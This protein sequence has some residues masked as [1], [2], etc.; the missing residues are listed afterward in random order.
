MNDGHFW[1][2]GSLVPDESRS[3]GRAGAGS[4]RERVS[5]CVFLVENSL[6]L[7]GAPTLGMHNDEVFQSIL[8]LTDAQVEELRAQGVV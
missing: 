3:D 6:Q 8:G 2:R 4:G 7:P 5:Q 1:D